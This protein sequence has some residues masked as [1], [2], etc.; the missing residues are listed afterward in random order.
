MNLT[1]ILLTTAAAIALAGCSSMV[2]LHPFITGQQATFDPALAGVWMDDKD[3]EVYTVRQDGEGYKVRY[4]HGSDVQTFSAQLFKI[5]DLRIL[6]L[7]STADDPFQLRVHTPLRVWIDGATLRFA[8]L[9][10][11]WLKENAGTQL[12]IQNIGDRTLIT[13]PGDAVLR[14]LVTYGAAENAY[15]K[16]AELHR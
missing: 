8:T 3:D 16:P 9:D 1:G 10:S 15:R 4:V 2:S 12:A 6:D 7:V 14:F 5:G 13:A 11:A